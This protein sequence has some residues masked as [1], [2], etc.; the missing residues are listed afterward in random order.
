MRLSTSK[1][2]DNLI[3][4]MTSSIFFPYSFIY[5]CFCLWVLLFVLK[6]RQR[7][8]NNN[9]GLLD[10]VYF[11]FIYIFSSVKIQVNPVLTRPLKDQV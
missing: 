8:L 4:S 5:E 7:K 1:E 2:V 6:G 11:H 3:W 10:Q 9:F